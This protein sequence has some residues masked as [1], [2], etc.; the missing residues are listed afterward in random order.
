MSRQSCDQYKNNDGELI[1]I[2]SEALAQ[3]AISEGWKLQNG[4]D[5]SLQIW[6]LNGVRAQSFNRYSASSRDG[7]LN[8]VRK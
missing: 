6:V 3:Q 7:A 8:G 5:Y 4:Y 2:T 1:N